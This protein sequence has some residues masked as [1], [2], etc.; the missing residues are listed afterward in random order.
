MWHLI[1]RS[2]EDEICRTVISFQFQISS[3]T[4]NHSNEYRPALLIL[5]ETPSQTQR[6]AFIENNRCISKS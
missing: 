3:L 6:D 4:S 5:S 1:Q 2:N